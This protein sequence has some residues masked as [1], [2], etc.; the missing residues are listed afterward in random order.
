MLDLAAKQDVKSWIIKR[1]M[2]ETNQ[3]VVDMENG[4]ARY[5]FV[6]EA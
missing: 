6:L 2:S 3:A 4:K 5:R 1:P